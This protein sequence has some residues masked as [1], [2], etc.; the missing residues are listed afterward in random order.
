MCDLGSSSTSPNLRD[1]H[2]RNE[3]TTLPPADETGRVCDELCVLAYSTHALLA[4]RISGRG[5]KVYFHI[6]PRSNLKMLIDPLAIE[7][8]NHFVSVI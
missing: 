3:D 1:L 2:F 7:S 5:H 6:S 8:R 4:G